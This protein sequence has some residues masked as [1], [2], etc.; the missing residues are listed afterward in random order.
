MASQYCTVSDLS[1]YGLQPGALSNPARHVYSVTA[2]TDVITA[3][4]HGLSDGDEVTFRVDAVGGSL[5]S[6]LVAGDTYYVIRVTDSRFSVSST[7]GGS[8]IDLTT[9][10]ENVLVASPINYIAAI[11]FGSEVINNSLP[12]HIVP[13]DESAIPTI[14]RMT[15][16]ELAIGKLMSKYGSAPATLS[17]AVDAAQKR[18]ERWAKGVPVRGVNSPPRAQL[19]RAA[20]APY[21]DAK[22]WRSDSTI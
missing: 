11:E 15:C 1:S 20:T 4:N 7:P 2:G 21:V 8:A 14:V 9:A 6:P 16:A 10:G 17:A 3:D 13:I 18:I 19:S 22:G 12:A 5:P